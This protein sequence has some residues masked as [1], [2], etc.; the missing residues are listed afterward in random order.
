MIQ[1]SDDM[2]NFEFD[3]ISILK[4]YRY[5]DILQYFKINTDIKLKYRYIE[6]G[7]YF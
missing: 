5:I 3:T 1:D 7:R 6:S 2:S 4:K